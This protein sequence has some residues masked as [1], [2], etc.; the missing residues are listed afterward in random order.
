[1]TT[2]PSISQERLYY[3]NL[4]QEIYLSRDP[5]KFGTLFRVDEPNGKNCFFVMK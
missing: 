2:S 1:M 4:F 3:K 5:D